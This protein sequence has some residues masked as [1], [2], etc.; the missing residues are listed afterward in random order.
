MRIQALHKL[1]TDNKGDKDM[2]YGFF[3]QS[4]KGTGSQC[5]DY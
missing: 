1:L 3:C 4:V 5:N 2:S